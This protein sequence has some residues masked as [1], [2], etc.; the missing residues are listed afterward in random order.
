MKSR[1]KFLLTAVPAAIGVLSFAAPVSPAVEDQRF[2]VM[3]HFAQGWDASWISLITQDAVPDVRDELYWQTVEPQK[4]QFVFP[5]QYER[6]MT[7]LK[8]NNISPLIILSF[9]NNN[10]D[11]GETPYTE[12]GIAAYARYAV[13][14]LRHYGKQIK[15]VEIWNE[16]NGTFCKGPAAKDRAVTYLRM[17]RVAYAALK[18][19]RPDV[20]VVAGATSGIPVPYWEKLLAGG[21]LASM[22]ALAVHPYRYELPPEGLE[23]DIAN[24]QNLVRKYNGGKP[25]PIWVTEI[26][27]DTKASL[28]P[29]DLAIDNVIQAK[30]LVRAYALLLSADVKRVYWY[31]LHDD[32]GLKMGL[33]RDDV[34]R[35][36]KPAYV[37][38]A[39]MIQQLRGASFIRREATP[40]YL[41]SLVFARPSGDMV[42]VIWSLKPFVVAV[43]GVTAVVDIQG[44]AAAA[45]DVLNL[46]DSP[47]FVTGSL[48]GLPAASLATE[49]LLADSNLDFSTNQGGNGWS[50]GAFIG[51]SC[52]FSLLPTYKITDWTQAWTGKYPFLA[53]TASEQ[54][55][56]SEGQM[57]IPAVRR[58]VSNYT[59]PVRIAGQFRC[60]T[61]GDGVGVSIFVDGQRKFRQ[62]LGGGSGR[63]I[64]Q[65]FDFIQTVHRGTQ[66][67]FSVDPGPTANIDYD[68]TAVHVTISK[69]AR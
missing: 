13:E 2:G 7:E 21:G 37:A 23:V 66:L 67:D 43:K 63:P 22:D 31:L 54:H 30:F 26:G 61:Q 42:R 45:T 56:S 19:E 35:S 12:E 55:P 36:P 28:A 1:A 10:Y 62:L 44:N 34:K 29:G 57:P 24:L 41:Y 27:W 9:E 39:T 47:L 18:H 40:S 58:W 59:G 17:L 53:L 16:Y 4:G 49:T 52:A 3:T 48:I 25:K 15:A 50:Y 51:N 8:K 5:G 38:M 46:N 68:A 14:V 6:Y 32:N 65:T 11:G 33:I 60:G 69:E 20:I 64:V